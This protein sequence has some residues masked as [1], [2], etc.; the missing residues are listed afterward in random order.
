M[1]ETSSCPAPHHSY[2]LPKFIFIKHGTVE[3]WLVLQQ[4]GPEFK[5]ELYLFLVW[6]SS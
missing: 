3:M 4:D 6:A 2:N 1:P 5:L